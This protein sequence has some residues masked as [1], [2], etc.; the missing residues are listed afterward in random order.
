MKN[1][2]IYLISI[3]PLAMAQNVVN[4]SLPL[5]GISLV[6]SDIGINC[7]SADKSI[8]I[9]GSVPGDTGDGDLEVKI[10]GQTF[11]LK[12]DKTAGNTAIVLAVTDV[13][14]G[15]F[16][17]AAKSI[18]T[19]NDQIAL[20]LYAM[21]SSMSGEYENGSFKVKFDAKLSFSKRTLLC[22]GDCIVL[23]IEIQQHENKIFKV[24]N[25]SCLSGK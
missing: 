8:S 10:D 20:F 18:A 15:V 6:A 13:M 3:G 22:E 7:S 24:E 1:F 16:T 14:N 4:K 17:V 11:R 21:P 9:Y 19:T 23:P 2:F 5:S 12:D 25:L